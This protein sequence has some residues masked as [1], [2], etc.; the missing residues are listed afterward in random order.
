MTDLPD[1]MLSITDYPLKLLPGMPLGPDVIDT[2]VMR[3]ILPALVL[4][5]FIM[6][7]PDF[8]ER[9]ALSR[10]WEARRML[11]CVYR[12]EM[13]NFKTW[14]MKTLQSD[15]AWRR[16]VRED[17]GGEAALAR[18]DRRY[19]KMMADTESV[20]PKD[21]TPKAP[22]VRSNRPASKVRTD[23]RKLFRLAKITRDKP[24]VNRY[25]P[26]LFPLPRDAALHFARAPLIPLTP[27]QLRDKQ[28]AK[29]RLPYSEKGFL[30]AELD[31]AT[32]NA[33][34]YTPYAILTA[35]RRLYHAYGLFNFKIMNI[36][37]ALHV[38]SI[39]RDPIPI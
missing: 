38:P 27:D 2:S 15:A 29:A 25:V 37:L 9:G 24:R 23:R 20:T 36:D 4:R 39:Q 10:L 1:T 17:L 6:V 14:L 33:P 5:V 12:T 35:W 30:L 8:I 26:P 7:K 31:G 21:K 19:A 3:S 34:T 32:N 11:A 16:E 22:P 18:W 28:A 13:H